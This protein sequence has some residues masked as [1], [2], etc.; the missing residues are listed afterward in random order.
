MLKRQPIF[1]VIEDRRFSDDVEEASFDYEPHNI[2]QRRIDAI[3]ELTGCTEREAQHLVF[4]L[5][6]E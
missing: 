1:V 2:L 4:S 6:D 5:S 3:C